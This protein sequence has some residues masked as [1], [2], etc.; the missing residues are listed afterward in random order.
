MLASTQPKQKQ[1]LCLRRSRRQEAPEGAELGIGRLPALQPGGEVAPGLLAIATVV[2]PAQL[3]QAVV[4][5]L[6]RHVVE[7]VPQKMHVTALVDGLGQHLLDGAPEPSM[8]VGDDEL[9]AG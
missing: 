7:C 4:V 3:L 8:G 2:E 1:R 5:H 9:D 6:A